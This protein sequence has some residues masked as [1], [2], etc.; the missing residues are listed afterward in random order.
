MRKKNKDSV[1]GSRQVY[2]TKEKV[3]RGMISAILCCYCMITVVVILITVMDSFKTKIDIVTNLTGLPTKLTLDN[4]ISFIKTG[5]FSLYFRNS[6]IL[7]VIGTAGCIFLSM[8]VAYG[9][10]RYKFKGRELL[11]SYTLIGSMVPI[12]VMILPIL[13]ILRNVGLTDSLVG[14]LLIYFSMISMS[15]LVFQKFFMTIPAAL[16]ESARLDGCSDFRVFVQIILPISKPVL[17]TETLIMA[18]QF[19]NDF[20][21]PMLFL[22]GQKTTTLTLA[23]YRYLTQFTT[24]MGESMAAVVITLLPIVILYFLFS[25]QIVEGLT[26]GA[27]KG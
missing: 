15:C 5:N 20:Y 7:T 27:V 13:L 21:I 11:A 25:S 10:A 26:G 18:I 14:V 1:S 2:S 24:Y 6:L 16:E 19:W 12:Q 9:I 3:I 4:Y 8:M 17:F 23:I 22:N